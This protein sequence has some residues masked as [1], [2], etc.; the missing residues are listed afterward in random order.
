[1]S[2]RINFTAAEEEQIKKKADRVGLPMTEYIRQQALNGSV[3]G[4]NVEPVLKH[5]KVMGDMAK[6][7]RALT[8]TPHPD[9]WILE[10]IEDLLID[11]QKTESDLLSL[12]RRKMRG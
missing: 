10:R 6:D 1:M 3:R 8:S 12:M 5:T 4:Y 7:I 11:L 2:I 9:R